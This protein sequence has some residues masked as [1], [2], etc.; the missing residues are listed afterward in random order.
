[1]QH[2]VSTIGAEKSA[3]LRIDR[4]RSREEFIALMQNLKLGPPERIHEALP[5]NLRCGVSGMLNHPVAG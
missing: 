1:M 4:R 5:T 3:N 2:A